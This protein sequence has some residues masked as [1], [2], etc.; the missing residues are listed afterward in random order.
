V[1][2]SHPTE[3]FIFNTVRAPNPT[4]SREGY[5]K[6]ELKEGKHCIIMRIKISTL[7]QILLSDHIKADEMGA[8]STNMK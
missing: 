5:L 3:L 6:E 2:T 4:G 1:R 7:Y 8:C